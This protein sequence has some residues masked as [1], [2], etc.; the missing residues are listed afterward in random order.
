MNARHALRIVVDRHIYDYVTYLKT[1]LACELLLINRR[2]ISFRLIQDRKPHLVL[3]GGS[4]GNFSE[5]LALINDI[6]SMEP[7]L[8]IVIIVQHSSEDSAIAAFRAGVTDYLKIPFRKRDLVE[9]INVSLNG[10]FKRIR[11]KGK[12]NGPH[13][14]P[15]IG[16]SHTMQEIR[17]YLQDVATIDSNVL[18]SGE[19]GTGKELAARFIHENSP[20]KEQPFVCIN[21]AA[22]PENLVESELFGYNRGAFT[23]AVGSKPGKFELADGGSL[24]LDEIGEMSIYAQA[25]ILRSIDNKE[26][27]RLGGNAEVHAN[28][29]VIAA[30]NLD[31]EK[32][33]EDRLF[34]EDLYYRLNVVR[35][36]MPPLKERKEDIPLIVDWALDNLN[37]RYNAH[38]SGMSDD[39]K[40]CLMRYD[41]P[42]N[43]R[44]LLNVIEAV[45]IK[46]PQSHIDADHLP[47]PFVK[48]ISENGSHPPNERRTIVSTLI[49]TKWNKSIAARQLKWS[50]MTLY[51]KM[52]KYNIVERRHPT[53]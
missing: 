13:E 21:C 37:R 51:R 20:R 9:R 6:R 40:R 53:R 44:E 47:K 32:L 16:D 35:I 33:V 29:R 4:R 52:D 31:P 41:W 10:T 43:V 46:P 45:Y 1:L 39:V 7:S 24:F 17:A 48:K 27:V 5:A 14:H 18:I 23:G 49:E 36:H 25:K 38:V 2:R 28:V 42:G 12:N 19:T 15:M 34:R 22:L 11:L 8:P 3:L 50:R 30:T 26:I